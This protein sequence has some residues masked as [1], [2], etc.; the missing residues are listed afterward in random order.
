MSTPAATTSLESAFAGVADNYKG[1]DVDLH[2][3]YRDMR[4][5]SPVIAE[6]FMARLG[7]PNIAGL[8][9]NRPTFTLFKYKDV[10]SV[11]RDATHFTS[12]FIAEGLG[13]FFDGLILTGMDGEAH[14]RARS[15]LQPVFMPDVVNRWRETKMAPIVR[16]EYIEPMVPKRRADL[17]D[18]GLHF[19]IRLIYSLIGF[20]D[21]R[22]EQIEQYAAWALAIL[23][24]PQVDAEKAAQARKAAMEAAQA[25]YDAVK[26]EVIEV[27]KNGAQGDDLIS[28]LIRAE[29]EGRSLDDHEVA[30]FVRS[31]LPAAGE[32]T[33]RTFGSLMVALLERPELL[34]R[35]R[36]D[37]SLVPKAIDEA[38]RFEPVA[39][40]KV[41]QAAQDTEIGGFRI[42]KGAMVQC[43]VSSAN[44]DEEVFENSESFD[45]D[46]KLKPSFGFGFGPHMCIGQF[47]AKVEL[48]VAVN[49]ILDLLPNL[50]LDPEMPRPRIVGAQL[51]GP[52][53]LH[54]IWD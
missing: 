20:P 28:R 36:A 35:V 45:I 18:F 43:I 42:P 30:T 41:R 47:I 16:S 38:V 15:L 44:R 23:A 17:M 21:N 6:D 25:L 39:T 26:L 40:F 14:R 32:T 49:T 7:V 13:A 4:R 29:Y 19:P 22:P 3:I 52:H 37:R 24:G 54:V 27:R 34:E 8:D 5:N 9:A 2:A 33:T 12:G 31:L 1:S 48:A 51:R 50:R 10:M 53:A 46:R 11:L